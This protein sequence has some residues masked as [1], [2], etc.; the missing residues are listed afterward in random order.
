LEKLRA[1]H[2]VSL[3]TL[4]EKE[5]ELEQIN[6]ELREI[7]RS[8]ENTYSL[9]Q[10]I[11][12]LKDRAVGE[13][14][15]KHLGLLALLRRDF[16]TLERLMREAVREDRDGARVTASGDKKSDP[17]LVKP[18]R[19]IILFI[20]DLD[21][22]PPKRVVE[23]L[24]AI[25]MLLAFPLFVVVVGVDSRWVW[26]CLNSHYGELL[27][28]PE[29][30]REFEPS[31]YLEKIFQF[32]YWL[33]PLHGMRTDGYLRK[34]IHFVETPNADAQTADEAQ[35]LKTK[36]DQT[37]TQDDENPKEDDVAV[38]EVGWTSEEIDDLERISP[39]AG[40]T[41]RAIKRYFNMYRVLRSHPDIWPL[42]FN[43][44][45]GDGSPPW[46]LTGVT[47]ALCN[48]SPKVA[49]ECYLYFVADRDKEDLTYDSFAEMVS[50][51]LRLEISSKSLCDEFVQPLWESRSESVRKAFQI[52][53]QHSFHGYLLYAE[54]WTEMASD[55]LQKTS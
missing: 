4:A 35:A 52:S 38:E 23:V 53:L 18:I 55:E 16:E 19:R 7:E 2:Q 28:L 43:W 13:D 46:H 47:L 42:Y 20:D 45:E 30:G 3:K 10:L 48:T 14:Y 37:G 29:N 32:P 33:P 9:K 34:L 17:L 41:P 6:E 22:C 27:K 54:D 40:D 15:N 39:L 49:G 51:E 31:N 26:R 21:R 12:F 44:R 11:N 5:M 8:I 25:H 1:T 50:T 24:Q 36:K